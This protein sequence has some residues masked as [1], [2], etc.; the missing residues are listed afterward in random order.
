MLV[1]LL[2]AANYMDIKDLLEVSVDDPAAACGCVQTHSFLMRPSQVMAVKIACMT[3]G[4]D[5]AAIDKIFKSNEVSA[6]AS[7]KEERP[8]PAAPAPR[9]KRAKK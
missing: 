4:K 7:T 1:E 6:N 8:E 3:R 9:A 2:F 5:K